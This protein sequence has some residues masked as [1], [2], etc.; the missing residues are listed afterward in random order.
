MV[1]AHPELPGASFEGEQ[2]I[3]Q[4]QKW[5]YEIISLQGEKHFKD[6][7]QKK[8]ENIE[9]AHFATHSVIPFR[10]FDFPGLLFTPNNGLEEDG[11]LFQWELKNLE[12]NADLVVLSACQS[13]NGTYINGEGISSISNALIASGTKA[14]VASIWDV[15]DQASG[16]FFS[17]FYPEW[18]KTK[19]L[20]HALS[21]AQAQMK[22][23]ERFYD[24]FY[25][26]GFIAIAP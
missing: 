14:V 20:S 2:V 26:A 9:L 6:W 19:N 17:L 11:V 3:A 5:G 7:A 22:K 15:G 18:F 16:I 12:L 10:G 13:A 23:S 21:Y 25:W 24:P 1:F 8:S 4:S